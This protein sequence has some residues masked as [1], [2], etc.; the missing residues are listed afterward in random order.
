M[1]SATPRNIKSWD[2]PPPPTRDA[3]WL[4]S[5][6]DQLQELERIVFEWILE[7]GQ[8]Q[9]A[10]VDTVVIPG[11]CVFFRCWMGVRYVRI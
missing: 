3:G 5:T 9:G 1:F 4:V 8:S 10:P 7:E 6:S 2:P 11:F